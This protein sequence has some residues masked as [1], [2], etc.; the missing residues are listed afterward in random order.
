MIQLT[1]ASLQVK[2]LEAS[3]EFYTQKLGF[4]I[5]NSNPQACIFKYNQGQAS[6]AIRT[7]LEPI[8]EKEL[9]IGV[10]LWFAVNENVDELKEKLITNGITTT[11][12]IIETPF[13]RAFHV[14][15][16]D[17]YKLT[18]LNTI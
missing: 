13:G 11:G 12:P 6:F 18:F 17:G 16:L 1:F 15:D 14:K 8:E 2:N 7:P 3:K 4:E 9:G 5:D 10:A